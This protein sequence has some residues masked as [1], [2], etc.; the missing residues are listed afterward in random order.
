[1]DL[2]FYNTS[3]ENSQDYVSQSSVDLF[4]LDPPY[5]ISGN[6]NTDV[7]SIG[8]NSWDR[9]WNNS[10]EYLE[11]TKSFLELA[12]KQLKS[13]G[14]LYVC[15][16]WQNSYLIHRALLETGFFIK[17]RITW[18]RDKGRGSN[19]NW[20]SMH[21]DIFFATKHK[22]D[23]I[24]NINEV[25]VEKQVIAPYRN[26][27]GSPK[28]WWINEAGEKVRMTYP[29]NLWT[30]FCVPYWSMK[31]VKSYAITKQT[32]LNT[33]QKHNTQK[34]KA[35]VKKCILAS[36]NEGDLVVDYFSGSGTT[37]IAAKELNRN[38]VVF[39]TD[40]TCIEM[41]KTRLINEK[42]EI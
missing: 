6:K 3:F 31:E 40:A 5:Y 9:Q 16:S 25:M 33:L 32:P 8:R 20:K 18:K 2:N 39:D 38:C 15:I 7:E 12:H 37:A 35:L 24:F 29:G 14:S 22:N 30:E 21:E 41:L 23:Y 17:N 1:M 34:P 13:T 42:T 36:S 10:D 11:W 4:W 26:K 27:D 19:T 28:D